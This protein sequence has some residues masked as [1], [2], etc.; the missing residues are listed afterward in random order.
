MIC[1]YLLLTRWLLAVYDVFQV[2]EVLNL[3]CGSPQCLESD[4]P[5]Q[6]PGHSGFRV[7]HCPEAIWMGVCF[8]LKCIRAGLISCFTTDHVLNFCKF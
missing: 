7:L 8:V 2:M 3:K 6:N 5:P 4:P 1:I